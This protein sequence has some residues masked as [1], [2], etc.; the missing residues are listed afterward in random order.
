MAPWVRNLD[1]REESDRETLSPLSYLLLLLTFSN[2][3][4]MMNMNKEI[5][6]LPSLKE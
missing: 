1:V 2:V 4:S 3:Q 6:C 5:Y